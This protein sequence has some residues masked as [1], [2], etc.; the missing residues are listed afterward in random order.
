LLGLNATQNGVLNIVFR[1]A[2]DA[3]LLLLD[4]KDLRAMVQHVGENAKS[5]TAEYGNVSA[6]SVG[7]IQ[8]GLLEID[9]QGAGAFFGEPALDLDDLRQ[10]RG[11][12]GVVNVLA[13]SKLMT[14]PKVYATSLL[15]LLS[16]LFE[17]LPEEG[18]LDKPKLVFFFDEAHLLF[19]D[20]PQALLERIELVVRLIRSKGVGV[21]F[22]TQNP[23]D[24]P[25]A[26]LAQLGNRVQ[27]AL[28][29]YTPGERKA[30]RA[31]ADAFR[32][33]P[34]FDA[35][36]ALTE[37][38][39]GEALVSFLD[40]KGQ[41]SVVERAWVAPPRCRLGPLT[42]EERKGLIAGSP[43]EAV[44]TRAIDRESAY[45]RLR[46]AAEAAAKAAE[47]AAPQEPAQAGGW[48]SWLDLGGGGGAQPA[49]KPRGRPR[50]SMVETVAKS[51]ARTIGSSVGREIVR[52]I[53]GGLFGGGRRRR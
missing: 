3:G 51:A 4:L 35:E 11:G 25:E 48:G 6:A 30:V 16:E 39:V 10:V 28:R 44:Y 36:Q 18:D 41:P 45:E 7:A 40:E 42:P 8:R 29:A 14:A 46:G 31:A 33:N 12:R 38:A 19:D 32:P 20:A 23:R 50:D 13:A 47:A 24:I 1:A 49:A 15:W 5:L 2:D 26:V 53:L 43:L 21:Y 37:L 52:G 22:V 34:A 9:E 27:H 17:R